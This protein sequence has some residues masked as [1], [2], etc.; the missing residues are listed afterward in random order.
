MTVKEKFPFA[1]FGESLAEEEVALIPTCWLVENKM[2]C[3]WPSFKS[4][5]KVTKA[6]HER[7]NPD[8]SW[9]LHSI[10]VLAKSG[11]LLIA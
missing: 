1:I 3:W 4:A 2:K 5:P 6:V 10:R 8:N 9:S 7:W 11:K